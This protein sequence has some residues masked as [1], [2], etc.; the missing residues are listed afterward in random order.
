MGHII[1]I[2]QGRGNQ[3]A[4][5]APRIQ[6]RVR[7]YK[8]GIPNLKI[9]AMNMKK[10][11]EKRVFQS[12]RGHLAEAPQGQAWTLSDV[13]SRSFFRSN[14]ELLVKSRFFC[15]IRDLSAILAV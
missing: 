11:I 14:S 8:P 4:F 5:H 12:E 2:G 3:S 7:V 13:L 10:P 1:D 9:I 6:E 15:T